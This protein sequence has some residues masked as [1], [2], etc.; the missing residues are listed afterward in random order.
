M[1]KIKLC[2]LSR[3]CD[4]KTANELLPD[5]IGFIFVRGRRRYLEPSIAIELKKKLDPRIQAVGVFVNE[6][7][8]C[9]KDF[10]EKGIIDVVQ[11]HGTEDAQ[12]IENLRTKITCPV[13][14]AF[15][16]ENAEDVEKACQSQA[17]YILLDAAGGGTGQAFDWTLIGDIKRPYLLAGGLNVDNIQEAIRQYDPYGVDVSSGIETDGVKDLE[18]MKAFVQAVRKEERS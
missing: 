11:L 4:I 15:K 8:D 12:Y 9:I 10:V 16:V 1:R 17:D 13:I 5:F 6:D 18:K 3:E 14:K 2:G 7:P